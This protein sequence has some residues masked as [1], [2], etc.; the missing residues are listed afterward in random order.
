[1]VRKKDEDN[2][3][4]MEEAMNVITENREAAQA[5]SMEL[6]ANQEEM[7]VMQAQ[8]R[9]IQKYCADL[10]EKVKKEHMESMHEEL[11]KLIFR[12]R[13]PGS[14]QRKIR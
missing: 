14:G 9:E 11:A 8:H 6:L 1:M 12:S 13:P 3:R 7:I 2:R 4:L 5:K 10:Q